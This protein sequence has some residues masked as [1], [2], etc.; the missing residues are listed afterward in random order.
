M[1]QENE[2]V[3]T[4]SHVAASSFETY[5]DRTAAEAWK[6]LASGMPGTGLRAAVD[7]RRDGMQTTLLHWLLAGLT[8]RHVLHAGW[9]T[10]AGGGIEPL[11]LL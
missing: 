4:A 3:P 1:K 8:G 11:H 7:G 6:R 10:R 9:R 2:V 5:F